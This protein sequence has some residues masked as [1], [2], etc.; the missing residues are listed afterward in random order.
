MIFCQA[1]FKKDGIN[2][3]GLAGKASLALTPTQ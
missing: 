3:V 1:D 2:W